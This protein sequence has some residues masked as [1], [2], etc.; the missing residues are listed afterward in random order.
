MIDWLIDFCVMQVW[1]NF[2][3]R[4]KSRA[5]R[6]LVSWSTWPGCT[7][8]DTS[9]KLWT[10]SCL[11]VKEPR[12]V[13][14]S[15]GCRVLWLCL[16]FLLYPPRLSARVVLVVGN[17]VSQP[18]SQPASQSV[19]QSVRRSDGETV[20]R[21]DRQSNSQSANGLVGQSIAV[22]IALWFIFQILMFIVKF[23][24]QFTCDWNKSQLCLCLF[25]KQTDRQTDRRQ[26]LSPLP[27]SFKSQS[28]TCSLLPF[29]LLFFPLPW[30]GYGI[31]SNAL[32]MW[33]NLYKSRSRSHSSASFCFCADYTK[34]R[35]RP[36]KGS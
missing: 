9:Q 26:T 11:C 19:S 20:R 6:P 18:A 34:R 15:S 10:F 30:W 4:R 21:S 2:T 1:S 28:P 8:P 24:C 25:G 5:R 32:K 23:I 29:V 33:S 3:W 27:L 31:Q 14:W 36:T 17:S 13:E 7:T 22:K 12:K 16:Y 35:R